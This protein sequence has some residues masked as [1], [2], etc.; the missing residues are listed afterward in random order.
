M[1]RIGRALAVALSAALLAAAATL[2]LR[3]EPERLY[4]A[5]GF[6]AA[7]NESGAGIELGSRLASGSADN[8]IHAVGFTDA[9]SSEEVVPEGDLAHGAASL[10]VTPDTAAAS[11]QYRRCDT[12]LTIRC[13]LAANVVLLVDSPTPQETARLAGAMRD[14]GSD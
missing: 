12:A 14:L 5:A 3:P 6:V 13:Y 2:L 10:I 4:S 1:I 7:A 11:E 9:V 8:A